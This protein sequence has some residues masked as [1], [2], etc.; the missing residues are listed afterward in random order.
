MAK[1]DSKCVLPCGLLHPFTAASALPL[2]CAAGPCRG[3][4]GVPVR[5]SG[6]ERQ[7]KGAGEVYYISDDED[8]GGDEEA[9][10]GASMVAV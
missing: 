8:S 10:P 5:M 1:I 6:G 2:R 3:S 4:A 7:M 9:T